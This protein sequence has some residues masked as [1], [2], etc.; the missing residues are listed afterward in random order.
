MH[1]TMHHKCDIRTHIS[2]MH[3]IVFLIILMTTPISFPDSLI[4][5]SLPGESCETSSPA[6]LPGGVSFS[7]NDHKLGIMMSSFNQRRSK[8]DGTGAWHLSKRVGLGRESRKNCYKLTQLCLSIVVPS[9]S[10]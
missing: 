3:S 2:L 5:G 7:R 4:V 10:I 1:V 8:M 9:N 6:Y